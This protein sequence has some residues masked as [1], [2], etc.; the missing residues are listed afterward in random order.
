MASTNAVRTVVVEAR[1]TRQEA[2]TF[3]MQLGGGVG[4]AASISTLLISLG[5]GELQ[6]LPAAGL[7]FATG[8]VALVAAAMPAEDAD[9]APKK[10]G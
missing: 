9:G 6:D 4:I 1:V 8:V 2:T 3:S 5:C 10:R 7:L